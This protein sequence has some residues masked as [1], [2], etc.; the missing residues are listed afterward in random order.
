MQFPLLKVIAAATTTTTD[1]AAAAVVI[2]IIIVRHTEKI[3][4]EKEDF[5]LCADDSE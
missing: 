4:R 1:A 2:V 3:G 5:S